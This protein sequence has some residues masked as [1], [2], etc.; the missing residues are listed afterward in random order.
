MVLAN[1]RCVV[2]AIWIKEEWKAKE[3]L[4][5][6]AIWYLI[7]EQLIPGTAIFFSHI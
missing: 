7:H 1:K 6:Q 3:E 4:K 2:S 5:A